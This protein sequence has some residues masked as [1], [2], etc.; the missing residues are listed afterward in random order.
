MGSLE[1]RSAPSCCS[2]SLYRDLLQIDGH[3]Y[4]CIAAAAQ[5]RNTVGVMMAT[6]MRKNADNELIKMQVPSI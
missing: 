1:E 4:L 2:Q 6:E 3:N 5:L